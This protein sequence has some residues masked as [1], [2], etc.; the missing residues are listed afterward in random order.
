MALSVEEIETEI[1]HLSALEQQRLVAF[2]EKLRLQKANS[3]PVPTDTS[4]VSA[5]YQAFEKA[6]LIGCIST[7]EQL[8]TTY[9]EKLDFSVKQQ[10][11]ASSVTENSETE[12]ERI[13]RVLREE[14]L[15]GCIQEGEPDLS[16]NYKKYLFR[17]THIIPTNGC[18]I[19]KSSGST[20]SC[21][22]DN[23]TKQLP[24]LIERKIPEPCLPLTCTTHSPVSVWLKIPRGNSARPAFLRKRDKLRTFTVGFASSGLCPCKYCNNGCT[25]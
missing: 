20:V 16:V 5:I 10:N 14:G 21:V 11:T 2:I 8:S 15:L 17:Q 23:N 12:G 3:T 18:T 25:N 1:L 22:S 24:S 9:K 13:I 6:G 19:T 4:E 7:D